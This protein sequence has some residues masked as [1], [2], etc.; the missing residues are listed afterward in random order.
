MTLTKVRPASAL[1]QA[2]RGKARMTTGRGARRALGTLVAA[3]LMVFV[4]PTIGSQVSAGAAAIDLP[5]PPTCAWGSTANDC[6]K[7][8][9]TLNATLSAGEIASGDELVLT[10]SPTLPACTPDSA[11][12][13]PKRD[14]YDPNWVYMGA[15]Y[16][17]LPPY[18][19]P[20]P[21]YP[22]GVDIEFGSDG[23]PCYQN[24][25][26]CH[27]RVTYSG[28][29]PSRWIAV[30]GAARVV[31][32][33]PGPPGVTSTPVTT[34]EGP[35]YSWYAGTQALFRVTGAARPTAAF[36]D[37]P[38]ANPG[39]YTFVS[40]STDVGG[41]AVTEAWDF[42]DGSTATGS[43][44]VHAFT[45]PGTFH[46]T[47]TATNASDATD[48]VTHDVVVKA[49]A[50][51]LSLALLD[52]AKPPL[53]P[54][55][56]VRVR[57][58]VAASSD[59]VGPL[60]GLV[61]DG[62]VV[63]VAPAGAFDVTKGPEPAPP[64]AGI[65]LTPGDSE[66][67]IV[68]LTPATVGDYTLTSKITGQDA[69]GAPITASA[70]SA[71]V[72][73]AP[74]RVKIELDP[75]SRVQDEDAD[76]PKPLDVT[77]K[78]TI[79]NTT[80][81][82][83]T[84]VNMRSL[85]FDRTVVGQPL[86]LRQTG[87]VAPDPI[88]GFPIE[89]LAAGESVELTANYVADDDGEIDFSSLVTAAG[90][91]GTSLKGLGRA[92][93]SIKPKYLLKFTSKVVNPVP[94]TLL[95]AGLQIRV[96]G[97]VRN[98]SNTAQEHL[99]PLFPELEG[100]AGIASVGYEGSVPDAR[101]LS[102][103]PELKLGPGE[104]KTFGVRV[105]TAYSDPRGLGDVNPHGGTRAVVRFTPYG[106]ATLEDST[107]TDVIGDKILSTDPDLNHDAISI[108]DSI[109][110]PP[111][112][113]VAVAGGI[114]VGALEG[115]WS[116]ASSALWGLVD[117]AK[118]PYT[119][120]RAATEFGAQ[121]WETFTPEEKEA[122]SADAAAYA[123]AVLLRSPSVAAGDLGELYS[124]VKQSTLASMTELENEWQ[125][126]DYAHTA[127]L[128][129]KYSTEAISNVAVPIALA[130]L[131]KAPAA[132]AALNRAKAALATRMAPVLE[133]A[134]LVDKLEALGPLLD[135]IENGTELGADE[136]AQ[137]YGISS[138]ELTELQRVAT[139]YKFL[140]TVRSRHA[141]SIDWITRFKALVKPEALKIKSVSE[142][143]TKLGY[144]TADIGS[145][146]FKK[147]TP[148]LQ[149]DKVGGDLD[150][151]TEAFVTSKGFVAGTP[152]YLNAIKR[153]GDRVKEWKKWEKTY[154]QWSKR[155]WMDVSFNY[156][157]NAIDDAVRKGTG[158]YRGFRLREV[159][160]GE[161]YIEMLDGK[162][163]KFRRVTGD[164]DPIAFTHLDGSPLTAEEH[165]AMLD[166]MRTSPLLQ[167]QHGESTT[168]T[169]GGVGFVV[170]QFK[171]GEPGLQIAPDRLAP[172]VVRL[173]P[174][175]SRWT[176]ARD[177]HMQWDGGWVY[178]GADTQGSLAGFTRPPF[179]TLA[180]TVGDAAPVARPRALP[181]R[182][183]TG[184]RS[185]AR[186]ATVRADAVDPNVGRCTM[187]F[188]RSAAALPLLLDEEG[189]LAELSGL[190]IVPSDVAEPDGCFSEGG[191][192]SVPVRP[193]TELAATA[194]A[195]ASSFSGSPL[196]HLAGLGGD[197]GFAIGDE[198]AVGAGT[199]HTELRTIVGPGF[200]LDHP[201]DEQHDEG[202]VVLVSHIAIAPPTTP[203]STTSPP[204][205]ISDGSTT[206]IPTAGSST[207]TDPSSGLARTGAPLAELLKWA[208]TLLL[209]GGMITVS[210]A[211]RRRAP[212][213]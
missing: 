149:Y 115:V 167:A 200:T 98:L 86:A 57:A 30:T 145:L 134:R 81:D 71:G 114:T 62:D 138:D 104:H 146:V 60:I 18:T 197:D 186:S 163:G 21:P 182:P 13:G 168:Y 205:A 121:V 58:T 76:G 17:I 51:S 204:T 207:S 117:L 201:L 109:P 11:P 82:V 79:E 154:Q 84:G 129:A 118:M 187:T 206:S 174:A 16:N 153:I 94:G 44:V 53:D 89:D 139:K 199:D 43:T 107:E 75:A 31:T 74:I 189:A 6:Q 152:E 165:A 25:A 135:T 183:P 7:I 130:K 29:L 108:D 198:I 59:G 97:E 105:T 170:D 202:E 69:G 184:T 178:A 27:F 151:L 144:A 38:T 111:S 100:N 96:E 119:T 90:P 99:G 185:L 91:G 195:G 136:I 169:K 22:P 147:P 78:V 87:G 14:C 140:L 125:T 80:D 19:P 128:Y 34:T 143:D 103:P 211:R 52:G 162:S 67:F 35:A 158:Q 161:F 175:K 157:G 66:S 95:D 116:F 191:V 110:I 2:E 46:V 148:L 33:D 124:K 72:I 42:G 8:S 181:G 9:P 123:A 61:F 39:E 173:N 3:L 26:D 1:G 133:E 177:Y 64:A 101:G 150:G 176:S 10:V 93:L 45:E 83:I 5:P 171:P 55:L 180:T 127:E 36:T 210:S 113:P 50:L 92:R 142:L 156:K 47:L 56:P 132:L 32:T 12:G 122:F 40:T 70:S 49:P 209:V 4:V 41:G 190:G 212:G 188:S 120:L 126:G 15:V 85:D 131:A 193:S 54:D 73:G 106:T 137:L 48:S 102:V 166:E 160:E 155:G 20:G 37:T 172:R 88:D 65:T 159:S 63:N 194:S 141:S 77:A 213:R 203:T 24:V 23:H 192:L 208:L 68:E 196:P 28:E 164:I 179:D 112:D